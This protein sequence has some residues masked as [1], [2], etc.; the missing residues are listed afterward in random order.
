MVAHGRLPRISPRSLVLS[1]VFLKCD[2]TRS[3]FSS[4]FRFHP[5]EMVKIP[6]CLLY[7]AAPN[8]FWVELNF[9]VHKGNLFW[10]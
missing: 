3:E 9:I 5:L 2:G 10:A 6:T 4:P 1:V 8:Y 7:V